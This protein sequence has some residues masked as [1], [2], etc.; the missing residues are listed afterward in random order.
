M[1][2]NLGQRDEPSLN[3]SPFQGILMRKLT[4]TPEQIG[5]HRRWTQAGFACFAVFPQRLCSLKIKIP[6]SGP[7]EAPRIC[8]FERG[9]AKQTR[10]PPNPAKGGMLDHSAGRQAT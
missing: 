7:A 1:L 10:Q 9:T 5:G 2:M 3:S 8:V 4:E 6:S